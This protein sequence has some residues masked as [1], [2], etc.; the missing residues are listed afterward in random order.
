[1]AE[2][3]AAKSRRNAECHPHEL[4]QMSVEPTR[5]P[6]WSVVAQLVVFPWSLIAQTNS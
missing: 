5:A 3:S 4:R 6:L 1:M 2:H